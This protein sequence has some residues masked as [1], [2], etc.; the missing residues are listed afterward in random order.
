MLDISP[1]TDR[2]ILV[3]APRKGTADARRAEEH[4]E[5]LARLTDTAGAQVVGR[6]IQQ[7]RAPDPGSY[8]G[9]GKL[10]EL[11]HM[12]RDT[13]ASLV[14]LD[15]ELSP[16]QGKNL[17]NALEVRVMDRA[18]L[19]LDIF[20][21]RARSKEAKLEVE[22]A[23][24]EYLLP[25]LARMWVHLSRIRGGIGLRGPGETQ[26]E[27]DRR[28]IRRRISRIKR[29]LEK[30]ARHRGVLRSGRRA[31]P[32]VALVGYTNAGKSSLLKALTGAETLIEDRL[33]ATLDTKTRETDLRGG[34]GS[35]IR[36]IDTVGFIRKL[37]HDL[38]A[39]FEAT[40]EEAAHAD[41]VLHI[42]DAAHPDWADQVDV[43]DEVLADLDLEGQVVH[44]FNKMD[45]VDDTDALVG[46]LRTRY[47]C[48]VFISAV[49]DDVDGLR[50]KLRVLTEVR[51]RLA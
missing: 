22:L 9:A 24:L 17:E 5:E 21:T 19:I 34:Q 41:I 51:T 47:D 4:L 42:I 6:L 39:S 3:A 18:E 50:E 46:G 15:E 10:R 11:Q 20:A 27:T 32:T 38:V 33:F 48:A 8:I 45:L 37:P 44:V 35:S 31:I 36:L 29:Q 7:V 23:Q 49:N 12:V 40:L 14:I 1:P 30:V 43:V 25:R 26:L 2:A 16:A 13:D 28:M